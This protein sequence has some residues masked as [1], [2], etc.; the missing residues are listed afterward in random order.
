MRRKYDYTEIKKEI[1]D[2]KITP[3]V[4]IYDTSINKLIK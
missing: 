1:E 2:L 4:K 3:Y